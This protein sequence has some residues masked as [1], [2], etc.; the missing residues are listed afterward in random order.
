MRTQLFA[1]M[2]A[3]LIGGAASAQTN[4]PSVEVRAE[5]RETVSVSCKDPASVKSRDVERVLSIDDAALSHRL[6]EQFI[7]AVT[8]ACKGGIPHIL[9]TLSGGELKWEEM[10]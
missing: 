9:V 8:G 2:T 5:T 3:L 4:L 1:G 7:A 10:R 6:R